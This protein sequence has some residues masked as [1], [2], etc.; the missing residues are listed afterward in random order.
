MDNA[1]R[2]VPATESTDDR[3][4]RLSRA[5]LRI[6]ESLEFDTV[7][8]EVLDSARS[9][10]A[11]RYG[12]MILLDDTGRVQEFLASGMTTEEAERL[13][14]TPDSWRIFEALTS[15]SQPLRVPDLAEHV[16]GL[17]FT[18]FSIPLPVGVFR[19]MAS[20]MLHRGFRV[21][22][23]FV[24]VKDDGEEFTRADEEVLAMFASQ[25]ALV[26]AN[27][28]TH[29]DERRAR[30]D[31]ETL[32]D[33]SPVGVVVFDAQTGRMAPFNREAL[34]I[35]DGLLDD[36]QPPEALLDVLTLVRSDGRE[37]SLKEI[38]VTEALRATE[39]VRSEEIV[40]RVPDGRSVSVLLNA[41]P[42]HAGDGR[43][44]SVIVTLQDMTDVEEQ[45]R[46][47]AE[48]LA[49]VSHELRMPLTSVLGAATA[50]QNAAADL[51]PAEMRQ[52]HRIIID[53]AEHMRELIGDLL[54]V[55][56]IET[57]V[58]PVDP[59]PAEVAA[60]VDRARNAFTST[61]GRNNLAIDVAHDLP[62]VMADRR[63]I[64]Q[65]ISNLLSNA[66][67]HS[68]EDSAIRVSA[69]RSGGNVEVSVADQ[70]RGIPAEDLPRLFRKFSRRDDRD[71]EGDTGLGL[72]ICKGIV[73]AH[74]GR[75]HAESD[76]PGLGARFVFT[77]PVGRDAG[78]AP[79]SAR[80]QDGERSAGT[81]L[82]VDDDPMIL[83]SVRDALSNAGFRPVVTEDPEEAL[84]LMGE[85]SPRLALLDLML[86]EYD[87]TE[88][89]GDLLAV[90]RIPVIFLSAYGRDEMVARVLEQGATDYIVKPFSPTELVARVRAALRR[91]GEP[92]V[93]APEEPFVLGDLTIDYA[94]RRVTVSGN[95][96]PVT[97]TEFDLLA[98]LSM[99]AGR[100]VP[101]DRLL[102]RVWSPGKPG[103]LRVLRTHL[104]KLRRKLGDDAQDPRF[105]LTEPRVGYRMET[106]EG[107]DE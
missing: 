13:W 50:L 51:D 86:P 74:G 64:V 1:P 12:V 73:E 19:F 35:V 107:V 72:A 96:V 94:Q 7:L 18:D 10:T 6:N 91:F 103:N 104:M 21:G 92:Q 22:H 48:F 30:A 75:I 2:T 105:I 70:G 23:V 55:A 36:G 67:R 46:L 60:L 26:I 54:D 45:E 77:L 106:G 58:L 5:S 31:L 41:S 14:L 56:R 27:A 4:S 78:P 85:H 29:R 76:G 97:P 34:R 99:E 28:R 95:P 32:I 65:V 42:I 102:R 9:L 24:G 62:L 49:M 100:V 16:R 83:R 52:F 57:G 80:Y 87:G 82:V 17:G 11:A 61:G 66:A 89:M 101:H 43:V 25:A 93:P 8:Q 98:E 38:P 47:R 90:S 63:R 71:T 37:V 88:L 40:L 44:A 53:R 79:R 39:T 69:V 15:I 68:P 84:A 59:E 33:T 20:P 3:L 81:V